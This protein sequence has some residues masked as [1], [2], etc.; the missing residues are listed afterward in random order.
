M[1]GNIKTDKLI[2]AKRQLADLKNFKLASVASKHRGDPLD[3]FSLLRHFRQ[4]IW[5]FE[6]ALFTQDLEW[7]REELADIS[8]MVDIIFMKMEGPA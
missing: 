8:N 3:S 6:Q 7:I 5:E 2:S 1:L 4:E